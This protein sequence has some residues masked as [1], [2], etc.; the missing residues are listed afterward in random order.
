VI[1]RS[2]ANW[3][4]AQR[5]TCRRTPHAAVCDQR[6][7]KLGQTRRDESDEEAMKATFDIWTQLNRVDVE[8]NSRF[9]LP[10]GGSWAPGGRASQKS[11]PW[12]TVLHLTVL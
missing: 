1:S 3:V 2:Q 8:D 11:S 12:I 9:W 10:D 4:T 6:Q 5:T 7:M